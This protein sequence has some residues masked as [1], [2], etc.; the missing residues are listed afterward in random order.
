MAELNG[1]PLRF[2]ELRAAVDGISERMLT[3][4]LRNLE[5]DGFVIR[6]AYPTVPPRV[7]YTLS[8]RGQAFKDTL[9]PVG[10]WVLSNRDAIDH[11]RRTFD[12]AAQP[13]LSDGK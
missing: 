11:S 13:H 1:H 2:K 8:E 9:R 3:V 7:E 6:T 4:T 10:A 12:R 5:R